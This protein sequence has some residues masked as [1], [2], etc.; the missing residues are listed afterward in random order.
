MSAIA[1]EFE[2]IDENDLSPAPKRRR[3]KAASP[4]V[5]NPDAADDDGSADAAEMAQMMQ[6]AANNAAKAGF[7][8]ALKGGQELADK[9]LA[10]LMGKTEPLSEKL[11]DLESRIKDA[12]SA[13]QKVK[14][15]GIKMGDLPAQKLKQAPCKILPDLLVQCSIGQ[16]GGNWPFMFGPT[17]CGKTVA[18]E[19]VAEVLKLPFEHV[20]CSEG[21]SETWLWGRQTPTGF[22]PGG[23]WKCFKDGGVFLFD[24][25]DAA[26]DNVWLS[27]NTML[28]NGHAYN[29]ISGESV[30]RHPD[31][32]AIAAAN[33]NGKGG[34]GAYSGRSRLDGAT[35]NRF[36]MFTV[37]YSTD[38]ERELCG[39]KVLLEMLWTIRVKLTEKKSGDVVSTR[40][41]KNAY[42]QVCRGFDHA[43]I[44]SCLALRMDASN[45]DLFKVQPKQKDDKPANSDSPF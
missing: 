28:A 39:D 27:I 44:L 8:L 2:V 32:I 25:A 42:L 18:A 24:E 9:T 30:K 40:D 43:K 21:M 26:N 19:Q 33:T 36:T 1:T 17:G 22:V 31:F 29:P 13:K 41:I 6:D 10:A 37:E 34:T 3:G 23:L 4:S 35:L 5:G 15:I 12:E 16:A 20:N 38:L 7:E 14:V 45:K 11:A